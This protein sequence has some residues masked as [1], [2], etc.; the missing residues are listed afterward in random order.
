MFARQQLLEFIQGP[1]LPVV[2]I[3]GLIASK[4]TVNIDCATLQSQSPDI[5]ASCGWNSCKS[6]WSPLTKAPKSSYILWIPDF[7]GPLSLLW[8]KSVGCWANLIQLTRDGSEPDIN[9]RYKSAPGVTVT[10]FNTTSSDQD[11]CGFA[12]E[13]NLLDSSFQ[14]AESRDYLYM[15]NALIAMGYQVGLTLYGAPYDWRKTTVTNGVSLALNETVKQIYNLTGKPSLLVA[16]SLGSFG[17]L[18][19]L[20]TLSQEEKDKYVANYVTIT[21]AL[22]GSPKT[23]MSFIGGDAEYYFWNRFGLNYP[24]Q[25]KLL[26]GSSGSID[27]LVKDPFSYFKGQDWLNE[28]RG[29]V[30]QEADYDVNTPEGK[31]AWRE[32]VSSGNYSFRWFPTPLVQCF[33]SFTYRPDQCGLCSYDWT[34]E[35]MVR[36]QNQNFTGSE[37]DSIK[38]LKEYSPL[39]N[40]EELM[41]DSKTND[42]YKLINPGVPITLIYGSHLPTYKTFEFDY[43]PRVFTNAST[44]A[45]MNKTEYSFG[46]GTVPTANALLPAMKWAWEFDNK[47]KAGLPN[48]KP[49]KAVELCSINNNKGTIYDKVNGSDIIYNEYIGVSCDCIPAPGKKTDGAACNHPAIVSDSKLIQFIQNISNAN[50]PNPNYN[51]TGAFAMSDDDL[52]QL[53]GHCPVANIPRDTNIYSNPIEEI[54]EM[55]SW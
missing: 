43:D 21:N 17:S 14:V 38:L 34:E 26:V 11:K 53:S 1:C 51:Q 5:F 50:A 24:A 35:P 49:V 6:S 42:I 7:S 33:S 23:T 55:I 31:A 25:M 45:T 32:I 4:L 46:D 19:L 15:K 22:N 40:I 48:A 8:S 36:V 47:E 18:N 16:H 27:L 10:I 52:K 30:Q 9:K 12:A 54:A 20:N 37:S 41:V 39:I 28:W 13:Q 44:Y 29:R 2:L 3:P